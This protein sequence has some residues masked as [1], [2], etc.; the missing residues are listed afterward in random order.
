MSF[1]LT[2]VLYPERP[3]YTRTYILADTMKNDCLWGTIRN[4]I[5]G[6]KEYAQILYNYLN[7]ALL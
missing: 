4:I 5:Y 2:A 3:E 7:I 6:W 1:C